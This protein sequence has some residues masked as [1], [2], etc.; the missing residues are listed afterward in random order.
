[1]LT[2][3]KLLFLFGLTLAGLLAPATRADFIAGDPI[4]PIQA[5]DIDGKPVDINALLDKNPDL[6]IVYFF[7]VEKGKAIAEKLQALNKEYGGK[8]LEIIALG[9]EDN[10]FALQRFA[11]ENNIKYYIVTGDDL[12]TADWYQKVSVLPLTLFV[13]TEDRTI[14]R[15]IEGGGTSK[16]DIMNA[17]AENYFQQRKLG[18]AAAIAD[19]AIASGED[20][21]AAQELKG[22]V[23][24]ADGKLDEAEKE[25]TEAGSAAGQAKVA[26]EKGDYDKAIEAAAANPEDPYALTV[27]SQAELKKGDVAAAEATLGVAATKDGANWKESELHNTQGRVAQ[28]KG[29]T[30]AALASYEQALSLDQYNVAALSNE[31]AAYRE[32]GQEGDLAMANEVLEKASKRAGDDQV[33][34]MM[35]KQVQ[36]ELTESNDIAKQEQVRAQIKDLSERFKAMQTDGTNANVDT[37]SSRPVVLA[38]L[39]SDGAAPVFFERAGTDVVLQREL[40]ATVQQD[41]RANI[42][43][44]TMLDKLLQELNLGS[45]ELASDDTQKRLGQVLSAGHLAFIDFAQAGAGIRMYIRLVDTETTA[46]AFQAF[47]DVDEDKPQVAVGNMAKELITHLTEGQ[48]LKGLIADASDEAAVLINL[49]TKHGV[50]VGQVFNVL[51]E[52]EPVEVGGRV[53][54]HRQKPVGKLEVTS[55][56]VDYATCK[57]TNKRDGLV[58]AKEMKIKTGS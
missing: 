13:Y 38:F 15:V 10:K 58:I 50:A 56:E 45:S 26:Y 22:F 2:Q 21:K 30:D 8:G 14:E 47:V 4:P 17:V 36:S 40:E 57:L 42:V 48:E 24:V 44:R 46:I 34:A 31:G 29:D 53:I 37:W 1:M 3:H 49:G 6:T 54:A 20:P 12:K 5:E 33:L 35:L 28:Q 9:F 27:K 11:S 19:Q 51:E 32:R 18:T 39:P 52:G 16:A 43:E 23:L 41:K 7:T 55:V 25:F